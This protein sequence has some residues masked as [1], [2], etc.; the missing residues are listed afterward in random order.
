MGHHSDWCVSS[1]TKFY[2]VPNDRWLFKEHVC[3][4][5]SLGR[6]LRH[7]RMAAFPK[8]LKEQWTHGTFRLRGRIP[9]GLWINP[10]RCMFIFRLRLSGTYS[11]TSGLPDGGRTRTRA[12]QVLFGRI[13]HMGI[14]MTGGSL[15]WTLS[16]PRWVLSGRMVADC[17]WVFES[18]LRG[19][20]HCGWMCSSPKMV[21]ARTRR[22]L[23][24][25]LILCTTPGNVSQVHLLQV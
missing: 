8:A 18:L 25:T 3:C 11:H 23:V 5:H 7:P 15:I 10:Y 1:C 16:C 20:G 12:C 4:N 6:N 22:A 24:S 19:T 9:R 17:R 13:L 21:Q 14:G 2:M